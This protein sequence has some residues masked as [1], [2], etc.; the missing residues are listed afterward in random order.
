MVARTAPGHVTVRT[1]R[2][3][4][5]RVEDYISHLSHCHRPSPMLFSVH[6]PNDPSPLPPPSPFSYYYPTMPAPVYA[7][8]FQLSVFSHRN[9]P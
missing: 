9:Q 6:D 5:V 8:S 4:D 7:P 2:D 1:G 3:K